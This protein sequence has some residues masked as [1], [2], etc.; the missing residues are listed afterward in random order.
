[1]RY[2]KI[3]FII[4][5]CFVYTSSVSA[6]LCDKEHIKELKELANQVEINYEYIDYTEEIKNNTEGEY[7]LNSYLV[8]VN[9]ISSELYIKYNNYDYY[10]TNDNNGLIEF[11][12]NSGKVNL[13]INSDTC[14]GYK[15]RNVSLNLPKF[16]TYSYRSECKELSEY[17]LD[18]CDPWYQGTINDNYFYNIVNKY[19]NVPEKKETFIDKVIKFYND[20]QLI[21]VGSVLLLILAIIG[22]ISYRKRSVLE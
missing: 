5:C 18:I 8:S 13:T 9:L 11:V 21:I 15:L 4:I 19:L 3:L 10:Y 12:V 2:K 6:D 16:N 17:E 1:M 20:Y 7:P 14:A 22:I